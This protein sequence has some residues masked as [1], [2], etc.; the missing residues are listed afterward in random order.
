MIRRCRQ[1]ISGF[2]LESRLGT[3]VVNERT[4]HTSFQPGVSAKQFGRLLQMLHSYENWHTIDG[5]REIN[6]EMYQVGD[7]VY[8]SSFIPSINGTGE[9]RTETIIKRKIDC[10]DFMP[11]EVPFGTNGA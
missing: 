3:M 6:V 7:Q 2:E 8:R 4:G 11:Q 10:I 5:W 1:V 9:S